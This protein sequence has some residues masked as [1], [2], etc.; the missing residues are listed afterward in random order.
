MSQDKIEL[1]DCTNNVKMQ[2]M[3]SE[4]DFSSGEILLHNQPL[5]AV[6]KGKKPNNLTKVIVFNNLILLE[7]MI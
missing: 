4:E 1:L 5:T 7:K 2:S 3:T 6:M